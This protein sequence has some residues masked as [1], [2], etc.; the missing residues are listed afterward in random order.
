MIPLSNH[1]WVTQKMDGEKD[2]NVVLFKGNKKDAKRYL[3]QHKLG[4]VLRLEFH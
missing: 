2:Y 4:M 1:Y 3:K